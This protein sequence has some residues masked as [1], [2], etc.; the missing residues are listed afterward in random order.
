MFGLP[1][2]RG[3]C[4]V[5]AALQGVFA[6]PQLKDHTPDATNPIDVCLKAVYDSRGKECLKDLMDC[7]R[8]TYMPAGENIG[9][10]HELLV[11]LCDKL[12][13]LDKEFRFKIANQLICK[14]CNTK[15]LKEDSVV[16]LNIA[17]AQHHTPILDALQ[18]L[19][20]PFEIEGRD[21]DTC[22]SK[23]TCTSQMMFG[24]FPRVLMIHRVSTSGSLD[25]SSVLVLNQRKYAL[26]AVLSFNGAHWWSYCRAMPP[27]TEWYE[28]DDTRV[29][30][31][32]STQFP[33]A[34][35]MRILL[36]FLLE[37]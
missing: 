21:C 16:E 23:Q 1:N 18:E 17:P 11:H 14:T 3:S 6:C 7:I 33:V 37:N 27:G 22:K 34:G 29:R 35:G 25:Y 13:W 20:A 10:S 30:Q 24:S 8:T 9:D 28:I 15:T 12:P 4:W 36:Y 32:S 5:N 19:V 31:M 26:F 2:V